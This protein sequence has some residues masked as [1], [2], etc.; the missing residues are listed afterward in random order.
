MS[1]ALVRGEV[2]KKARD[3]PAGD[4]ELTFGSPEPDAD[5]VHDIVEVDATPGVGLWVEEDLDVSDVLVVAMLD[6]GPGEILEVLGRS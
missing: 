5:A 1:S 4:P 3:Q 2:P 6:V